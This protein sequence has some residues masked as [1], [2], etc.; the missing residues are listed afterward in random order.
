MPSVLMALIPTP[1]NV[2]QDLRAK[3]V[4]QVGLN[5]HISLVLLEN[6]VKQVTSVTLVAEGNVLEIE[7]SLQLLTWVTICICFN[8]I[9]VDDCKSAPCKNNGKCTDGVDSYSCQCAPGY[10]G[11]NCETSRFEHVVTAKAVMWFVIAYIT[12]ISW[13][14]SRSSRRG[15][16]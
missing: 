14:F 9:D 10:E 3:I 11:E 16:V 15:R 8:V 12:C 6:A 2:L 4:K 1:V 5:I 7:V 13:R